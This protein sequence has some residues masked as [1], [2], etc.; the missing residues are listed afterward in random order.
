[1]ISTRTRFRT[2]HTRA[3]RVAG[4]LFLRVLAAVDDIGALSVTAVFH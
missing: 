3:G 4:A 2:R 1:V